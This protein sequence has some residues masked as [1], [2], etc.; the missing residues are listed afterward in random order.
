[1]IRRDPAVQ[2]APVIR[3]DLGIRADPVTTA[4]AHPVALAD[5]ADLVDTARAA[6]ADPAARAGPVVP[7]TST[8]TVLVDRAAPA[9]P[10]NPAH[11]AGIPT[12][13]I[14]TKP[15]GV[16][17]PRPGDGVSR[18]G[19]RGTDRSHR[20]AG[21]G[22]MA[23]STTGVTRKL[24]FGTP[25]STSGASGSSES[26][27]RCKRPPHTTPAL[28]LGEAGVGVGKTATRYSVRQ[29]SFPR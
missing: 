22:A 23:P 2:A 21:S 29:L 8:R 28:P 27:S 5:L 24:R 18:R 10:E 15:L 25:A 9:V 16:T 7:E 3:A 13:A 19:R 6:R 17:D 4:R 14:S 12:V 11:G 20:P 26:G 1:M